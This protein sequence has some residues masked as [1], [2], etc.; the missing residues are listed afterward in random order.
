MRRAVATPGGVCRADGSSVYGVC[1]GAGAEGHT[2]GDWMKMHTG[3][4]VS[5]RGHCRRPCR[6]LQAR[7]VYFVNMPHAG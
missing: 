7:P 1:K 5:D 6:R 2:W 4:M 3:L